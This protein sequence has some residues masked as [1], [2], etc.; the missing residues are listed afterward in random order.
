MLGE[1]HTPQFATILSYNVTSTV[2]GMVAH[3]L[4]T[5]DTAR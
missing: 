2:V 5:E 4:L 3:K 1:T